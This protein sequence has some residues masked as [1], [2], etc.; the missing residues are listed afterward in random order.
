MVPAVVLP[1][2]DFTDAVSEIIK[3]DYFPSEDQNTGS[4]IG[5]DQMSLTDFHRAATSTAAVRLQETLEEKMNA[6]LHKQKLMYACND[7]SGSKDSTVTAELRNSLFFPI[8]MTDRS[9]EAATASSIPSETM[10]PPQKRKRLKILSLNHEDDFSLTTLNTKQT[11]NKSNVGSRS[12]INVS[13]TRFPSKS[14][15]YSRSLD[16]KRKNCY[17][18]D[19]T[20]QHWEG[21]TSNGVD[22]DSCFTDLDATTI[23]SYSIRSEL[24]KAKIAASRSQIKQFD[25]TAS[26]SVTESVGQDSAFTSSN[27]LLYQLPPASP[28]DT[29]AFAILEPRNLANQAS[30]NRRHQNSNKESWQIKIP[31]HHR[32]IKSL[33]SAIKESSCRK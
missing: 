14:R 16:N 7:A 25:P 4:N 5:S 20:E 13:A 30:D 2:N 1:N 3:R 15:R 32:S 28:R 31:S 12:L 17:R 29:A 24:R 23:D 8:S 33:R 22:D 18:D 6:K 21:S 27:P 9:D 19:N 11:T 26:S 10:P